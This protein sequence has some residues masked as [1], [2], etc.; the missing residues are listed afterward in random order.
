M[1]M[2][3]DVALTTARDRSR[4]ST[5]TVW[6]TVRRLFHFSCILHIIIFLC[7]CSF[8]F[9][10][11][12]SRRRHTRFDCDWSSDVCSS[13]LMIRHT[14]FDCDW[15]SDVCSSDLGALV[16]V[17][18]SLILGFT[19]KILRWTHTIQ[20]APA[21]V[22]DIASRVAKQ[23]GA[24]LREVWVNQRSEERRVGKEGRSRWSPDH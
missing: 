13:D 6:K 15:S 22:R 11:F 9:F 16:T 12:S 21:R 10:F 5:V 1:Y 3:N 8:F 2:C 24:K 4:R 7:V 19:L 17:L 14:R 23:A 20:P 18:L